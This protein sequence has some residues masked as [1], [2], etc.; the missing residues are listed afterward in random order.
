MT[1][2]TD[3]AGPEW[4]VRQQHPGNLIQAPSREAAVETA[5]RRIGPMGGWR[6][7]LDLMDE[8]FAQEEYPEHA[9]PGG[10]TRSV[11]IAP[12]TVRNAP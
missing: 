11:I 3:R 5:T 10:Y 12:E 4:V 1:W 9:R 7:E 2:N 6:V 8:V